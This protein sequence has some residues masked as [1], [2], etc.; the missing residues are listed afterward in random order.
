MARSDTTPTFAGFPTFLRAPLVRP[1]EVPA[2]AVAISGAPHDSTHTSRLG[3]R[4]GPKGIREAS[5]LEAD[6]LLVAGEHGLIDPETGD[7]RF[8]PSSAKLVDVGDFTMYPTDIL[9]TT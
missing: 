1:D 9:K 2:D 4:Y 8:Q 3:T 6:R 5:L 7:R